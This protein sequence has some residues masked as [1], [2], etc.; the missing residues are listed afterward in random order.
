MSVRGAPE[1]V[2]M[3]RDWESSFASWA[4]GPGKTED[5]RSE[6]AI[7]AVRAALDKS[8]ALQKRNFNVF[9]QG[10][11]KNRVNV[12]QNS[13]VDIGI[14]C[15]STF[16]YD[17]PDGMTESQFNISPATYHYSEFKNDVEAALVAHFGRDSVLRGN[18]AFDI[19]ENSYRV[20]ADVAPFFDHRRYSKDGR[21][22]EGVELL[23]DAGGVII[24]WPE[25]HYENGVEKNATTRRRYKRLVR[26]V[27]RL[28]IEMA[29][30][31]VAAAGPIPGFL[32]ECLL[33]NVPNGHL[34]HNSYKAD[35][36][37]SLAHLFNHTRSK[38]KCEDWGE[39]SELKYLFCSSQPWTWQQAH[40]F[41]DAA[42]DYLGLE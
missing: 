11:Y 42:W 15:H 21:Y 25:Q 8:E 20:E 26:I 19:K 27:K 30:N 3:S 22:V 14:M 35:V 41:V 1:A 13:D 31:G 7:R 37:E 18:K 33:W 4:Q 16:F 2:D 38:E 12:R 40:G 36:R 6:N 10:S 23:P 28:C 32:I 24:N 5:E 17:L 34:G 9:L 39:V 29:E